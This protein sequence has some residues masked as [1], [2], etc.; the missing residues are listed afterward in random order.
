MSPSPDAHNR[1]PTLS[2][3]E[4][5]EC[6][7]DDLDLTDEELLELRDLLNEFAHTLLDLYDDT[8]DYSGQPHEGF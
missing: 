6:L 5:R 3:E 2:L 4:C 7:D 8:I 1:S